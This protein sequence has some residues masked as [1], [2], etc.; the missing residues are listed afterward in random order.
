MKKIMGIALSLS[1]IVIPSICLA[2][3]YTWED[4]TGITGNI[5]TLDYTGSTI[6]IDV[7]TTNGGPTVDNWY[8]DWIQFKITS[9][10]ITLSG[11][12]SVENV[13]SSAFL[14][15]IPTNDPGWNFTTS[16][17]PVTLQK[18]GSNLPNGGFNLLYW[19]GIVEPYT[20]SDSGVL[21]NGNHYQWILEN[22]D[23]GS[24]DLLID[25][26]LKVGYYDSFNE[27]SGQFDTRQMSQKVPEPSTL[28]L[29]GAGLI[30]FGI[31]GRRKLRK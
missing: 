16:A 8:I 17:S 2:V 22:V 20:N 31:L 18:F 13:E 24:Q 23:L 9:K 5:Y 10:A 1:F 12:L 26:T 19:T 7:Y 27:L 11:P 3:N 30:G 4:N 6:T 21:L 15:V 29:L 25:P 14:D 28:L